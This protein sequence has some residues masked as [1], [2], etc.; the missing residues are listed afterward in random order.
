[1]PPACDQTGVPGL[2]A[3]AHFHS[4]TTSGSASLMIPRTLPSVSPRQSASSAILAS[5]DLEASVWSGAIALLTVY[6]L[7][8]ILVLPVSTEANRGRLARGRTRPPSPATP[9]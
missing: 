9:G 7:Q 4:S 6:G 3:F 5:I 2:V 1:M 8:R